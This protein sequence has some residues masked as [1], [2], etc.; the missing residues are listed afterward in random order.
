LREKKKNVHA[1]VRGDMVSPHS[2]PYPELHE[3]NKEISY[4]PYVASSF[5][6]NY[7]LPRP[8]IYVADYALIRHG[9][10]WVR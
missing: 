9:K 8:P 10:V 3:F 5:Y 1:F 7:R 6:F 4:N 2:I